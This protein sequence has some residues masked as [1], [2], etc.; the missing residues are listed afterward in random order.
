MKHYVAVP[1]ALA[2]LS[3]AA[4]AGGL[5]RTGQSIDILFENGNYAEFSIGRAD[6]S[7]NGRDEVLFNP[8]RSPSGNVAQAFNQAGAGFKLDINDRLS[9]AMI[10]DQ[11]WGSD[12]S[13]A[14]ANANPL[15]PGS[16]LLGGTQAF[17]ESDAITGLLRYKFNDRFSL[18]GGLRWQQVE[19]NITLNGAAYG[20]LSGYSV[21]IERDR[22]LGWVA[23]AAYEIPDIA[24]RVALTYNSEIEH[25]FRTT[26]SLNPAINTTTTTKTPQS[27][28]L[29]FQT[30]IAPNTLLMGGIRW[31]DHSET[32][33]RPSLAGVDLIDLEDSTTFSLGVAR[34]FNEN[35][36]GSILFELEEASDD[37]LVS[38]LAP[39]NGYQSVAIGLQYTQDKLKISGGIRYTKLGSAFAETG[40]PDVARAGFTGSDAVSFGF[41]VGYYF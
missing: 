17:A 24:L 8:A 1:L 23:G 19:G 15:T 21:K 33:L 37:N 36:S 40:T 30:G 7:L 16:A 3:S 34:R 29:D 18:H 32:K 28:N 4:Q 25:E 22:A 12:I 31:A 11:P 35:W 41:K 10:Y 9:F 26:E 6:P 14:P 27:V 2:A 20:A 38:P 13:Y 39:T 5:D